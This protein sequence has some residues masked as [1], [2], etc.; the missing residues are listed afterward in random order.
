MC[1]AILAAAAKV[2][3]CKVNEAPGRMMGNPGIS[4]DHPATANEVS[5]PL[6]SNSSNGY[7][8][9]DLPNRRSNG[10]PPKVNKGNVVIRSWYRCLRPK[11]NL[12][13]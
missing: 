12:E 3:R 11:L 5:S 2:T 4:S 9:E 1:C 13:M 6:Q 8:T 10:T 7:M